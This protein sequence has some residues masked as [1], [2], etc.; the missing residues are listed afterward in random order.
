MDPLVP[1]TD[2]FKFEAE[3]GQGSFA[4]VKRAYNRKTGEKVAIKVISKKLSEE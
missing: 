3:L 2:I 4:S 1:I